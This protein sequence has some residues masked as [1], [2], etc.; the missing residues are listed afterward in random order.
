MSAS[1][2]KPGQFHDKE[3]VQNIDLVLEAGKKYGITLTQGDSG[4]VK[5]KFDVI[6]LCHVIEHFTDP[7]DELKKIR[8]LLK[9][10]GLLYISLPNIENF[11]LDQ[12]QNAHTYYFKKDEFLYLLNSSFFELVDF[13][14]SQEIHMYGV[15]RIKQNSNN[16]LNIKS[17]RIKTNLIVKNYYRK[18]LKRI[19]F[20]I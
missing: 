6:L 15:F 13:G 4:M 11:G 3:V 16:T 18:L 2:G 20:F 5:G 1:L 17:N 9:E 8:K 12:F 19:I 7:F 14:T 10:D